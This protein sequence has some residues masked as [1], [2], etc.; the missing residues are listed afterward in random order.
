ME[1]SA[2]IVRQTFNC[3][4]NYHFPSIPSDPYQFCPSSEEHNSWNQHYDAPAI[5]HQRN[6]DNGY[7]H[8]NHNSESSEKW[9]GADVNTN[10]TSENNQFSSNTPTPVM[11]P[12]R[13]DATERERSRMHMLNDAFDDLRQV[14]PKSNLSDHQKLSKIATL[15][16]AIHYISALASILKSTGND[17]QM[18]QTNSV[19]DRRGKRKGVKRKRNPKAEKET[20]RITGYVW[21]LLN[22]VKDGSKPCGQKGLLLPW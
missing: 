22:N 5:N 12:N 4:D 16:L 15:R 10:N 19:I 11:E 2:N 21:I 9:C 13:G 14:V 7:A 18:I 3:L 17:I 6:W 8:P 1:Y 20:K